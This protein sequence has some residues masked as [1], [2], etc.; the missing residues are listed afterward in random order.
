MEIAQCM[1]RQA[2]GVLHH[3]QTAT[4]DRDSQSTMIRVEGGYLRIS[5]TYSSERI[6][7]LHS[8]VLYDYLTTRMT[9]QL[10]RLKLKA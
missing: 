10:Q 7:Y 5:M 4:D 3:I 1:V 8:H 6:F 9:R 2:E